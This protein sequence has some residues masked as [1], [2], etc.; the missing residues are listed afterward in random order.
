MCNTC[1]RDPCAYVVHYGPP[2]IRDWLKDYSVHGVDCLTSEQRILLAKFFVP[3]GHTVVSQGSALGAQHADQGQFKSF[4]NEPIVGAL[5]STKLSHDNF[6]AQAIYGQ[7]AVRQPS[8]TT[9][10]DKQTTAIKALGEQQSSATKQVSSFGEL[11]TALTAIGNRG[12]EFTPDQRRIVHEAID[13]VIGTR[14]KTAG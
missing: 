8:E 2:Q 12:A 6:L 11:I 10:T 13:V 1:G 7:N 5:S 14:P 9:M 3:A 4:Y